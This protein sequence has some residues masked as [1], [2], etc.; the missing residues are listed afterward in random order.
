MKEDRMYFNSTTKD[1]GINEV[2]ENILN[3]IGK[4]PS[5][6]FK[7]MVGTD[8]QLIGTKTCFATGICVNCA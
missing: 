3:F 7:V 1:M 4:N 2:A 6:D 5:G 8:S